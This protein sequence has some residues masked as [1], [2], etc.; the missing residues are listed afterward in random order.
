M[1]GMTI[2]EDVSEAI[3]AYRSGEYKHFGQK[4]GQTL[5]LA[6]QNSVPGPS[7]PVRG[8]QSIAGSS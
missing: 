8:I 7:V 5:I 6:T 2:T 3:Q 4:I 1:N